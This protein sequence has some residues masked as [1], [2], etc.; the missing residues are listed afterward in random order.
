MN[1]VARK[2]FGWA[3]DQGGCYYYRL[4]VPLDHLAKTSGWDVAHGTRFPG[5]P[6]IRPD[7]PELGKYVA[8]VAGAYDAV[9]AQRTSQPAASLFWEH[10]AK[11]SALRVYE[12]DDDLFS[13]DPAS[14]RVGHN[15]YSKPEIRNNVARNITTADRVTVSTPK[16]AEI[17][18]KFNK[19]VFICPNA[20]PDFLPG[21]DRLIPTDDRIVIGWGGSRT[22]KMDFAEVASP[23]KQLFRR[24]DDIV[25]HTIG[26]SYLD[27]QISPEQYKTY[28][29]FASVEDYYYNVDF[30]IAIAPLRPHLFNQSK[31]YIKALEYAA[32]GI[33]V[34]ASDVGP[35]RDFVQHGVTG[36]LVKREHEWSRYLRGLIEDPGMR[37]E[38]GDA[39]RRLAADYTITKL[40]PKWKEAL[41]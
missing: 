30:D 35:Y 26:A 29:W 24:R 31:S 38:M 41:S 19:N 10:L 13:I 12:I 3:G 17:V 14:N 34:V 28:P 4:Q 7:H 20:I 18:S 5:F 40:L 22:H 16:L 37:G 32:L 23:L 11:T 39:A 2:V 36:F 8:E 9:V 15:F 27:R 33:P 6:S 21:L 25:F 1:A